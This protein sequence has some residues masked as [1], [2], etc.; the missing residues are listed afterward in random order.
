L[1]SSPEPRP[2]WPAWYGLAALGLALLLAIVAGGLIVG[3]AE[4]AGAHVRSNAPEVNIVATVIQD[5]L[6]VACAVWLARR[7]APPR[8]WHFGLRSTPFW[9]GVK[10]AAIAFAVYF[11]FQLVYVAAVHP[12][13]KQ[14]TLQDLGAGSGGL[15]TIVIGILVVGV[16]PFAEEFF[17]R[18][19][20]YGALRSRFPF[21]AAALIDGLVFGLVHAPTGIEAVPPLVALGFAFCLAYEKT[22]SI[23]PV[24]ALHAL[25]NMVAFGADKDGSWPVAGAV[26]G[27]VMAACVALPKRLPRG[28]PSPYVA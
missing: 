14:T 18:G 12:N 28:R 19:F 2:Q 27:T 10:W 17:F 15:W 5:C 7:T 4:A 23:F 16:A 9:R 20:F 26:A 22:G 25:N 13:Q 1:V 6:L 24:V 11:V 21:V 8:A 3:I